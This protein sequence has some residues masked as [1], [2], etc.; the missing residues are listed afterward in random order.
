MMYKECIDNCFDLVKACQRCAFASCDSEEISCEAFNQCVVTS[1]IA[2]ATARLCA[3][4][5]ADKDLFEYCAKVAEK[6][7]KNCSTS[8]HEHAKA[9]AEAAQKVVK[10]CNECSKDCEQKG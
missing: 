4:G 2:D 3:S 6:C 10:K 5:L 9:C 8:N 1:E 7:A